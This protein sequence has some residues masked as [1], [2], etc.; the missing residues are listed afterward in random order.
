MNDAIL[1]DPRVRADW[2]EG[3]RFCFRDIDIFLEIEI[4]GEG[5]CF[6]DC[7]DDGIAVGAHDGVPCD[8][9]LRYD[10]HFPLSKKK[11]PR[12]RSWRANWRLA[13]DQTR[14]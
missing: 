2:A 8:E 10:N 1:R 12:S 9:W 4:V 6:F 13:G 7:S 3:G 14:L 11:P 5:D